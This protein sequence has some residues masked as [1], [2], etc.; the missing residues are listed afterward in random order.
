VFDEDDVAHCLLRC[1]GPAQLGTAEPPYTDWTWKVMNAPVGGPEMIRLPDG[2]LLGGGRLYD[3]RTRTSLFWIDPES[4]Q[5]TEALTLPSGGDTSYPGMVLHDGVLHVSYYAS[6]EGKSS[7]YFAKVELSDDENSDGAT[8][9]GARLE[10]LV[11][12]QLIES[13]SGGA[14]L[15]LHSPVDRE[16]VITHDRPWEGNTSTYHTVF[17]DGEKYRMYYRGHH[18]AEH[19]TGKIEN[20][21]EVVCYAES[22]DGIHWTKPNLGLFEF[23]GSKD[24]NIVW[25]DG[26]GVHNFA[27]FYDANP[28][29]A[30]D[31]KYKAIG[32]HTGGLYA[33]RSSDAIHWELMHDEPVITKGAFDSLNLAFY[34]SYR[35]RYVDF[36]RGFNNGV[37]AVMT[38]VSDDF[39]EWSEPQWLEYTG[40]PKQHLYTNGIVAYHR[41]PHIFVGLP[42]RFMPGRNPSDH[43]AK[44][45][46]DAVFMSSRDGETFHRWPEAVVRPGLDDSRWVNRNNLP[47]WGIVETASDLPDGPNEL[48]IYT[49]EGYYTG[50][51]CQLRRHTWRLDGFVSLSAP[52]EGGEV[53]SKPIVFGV[54][55]GGA[56][57]EPIE[58]RL[59]VSTSAAGSVEVELLAAGEPI[60]GFT[61]ADCDT[62]VGDSISMPVSWEG[63]TDVS[64]LAGNPIR[65]RIRLRDADVFAMQFSPAQ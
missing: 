47:A 28:E 57:G 55:E 40:A 20:H 19:G 36:H 46:S 60:P 3:K 18:M 48:S 53:L 61:M 35:D 39:L 25:A 31:A 15:E 7:I 2:R 52:Y 65:M 62:L 30:P 12:D 5:L 63:A 6:H 50:D 51:S 59:N 22:D 1:S 27:P 21:R 38:A 4:A 64:S 44:G 34:D 41:A 24:N 45:V 26:P 14:E 32:R 17:N 49:T 23:N 16:V 11:D 54:P 37:R 8:D 33:F 29:A 13:F 9:L 58:L 43:P 10:P 56:A 42:K